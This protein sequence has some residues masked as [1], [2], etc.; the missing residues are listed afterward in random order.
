MAYASLSVLYSRQLFF[1]N[2]FCC[3]QGDRCAKHVFSSFSC[4]ILVVDDSEFDVE[5]IS[6]ALNKDGFNAVEI[7]RDG[8]EALEKTRRMNP[9][10]VILNLHMPNL[11]GFGYCEQVRRDPTLA[12]MPNI[13]QTAL[14]ARE[15]KLRALSCGVDDFLYKPVDPVELGL[16]AHIHLGR[17]FMLQDVNE[18]CTCLEME[19]NE[20]QAVIRRL[21]ESGA[22][23]ATILHYMNRRCEAMQA[24]TYISAA[25]GR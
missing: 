7:A 22:T 8:V 21:Q 13:V 10:L 15:A 24:M 1:V 14:D 16:R 17:Y 20:A 25:G 5:I 4:R 19:L 6:H 3:N 18:M 9:E 2:C 12:R 23:P 11:D